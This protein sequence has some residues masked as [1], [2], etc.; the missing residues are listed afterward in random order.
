M[1]SVTTFD[2]TRVLV[3][4]VA[5]FT[6]A[7]VPSAI[8]INTAIVLRDAKVNALTSSAGSLLNTVFPG[9]LPNCGCNGL[10]VVTQGSSVAYSYSNVVQGVPGP[11]VCGARLIYNE[12]T[13]PT[14]YMNIVGIDDGTTSAGANLGK[15]CSPV[16]VSGGV[17]GKLHF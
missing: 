10:N 12:A 17:V 11:M 5:Y 2:S 7:T 13:E 9:A 3:S 15:F 16:A 8:E 6:F 4:G 14:A 1:G